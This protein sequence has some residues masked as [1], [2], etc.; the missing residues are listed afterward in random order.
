MIE[1]RYHYV[2]TT[3]KVHRLNYNMGH[4][5]VQLDGHIVIIYSNTVT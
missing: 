5:T 1:A 3:K 4:K 2:G